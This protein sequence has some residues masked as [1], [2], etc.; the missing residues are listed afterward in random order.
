[1]KAIMLFSLSLLV[2]VFSQLVSAEGSK[3]QIELLVF[4]Q[5]VPTTEVFEQTESLIHWPT[6]LTELAANQY[7]ENKTL[8][9]GAEALLK[10]KGYQVILHLAWMQSTGPGGVILPAHIQSADGRLDG[11]I[12]LRD[13][14]PLELIVDLEHR[15]LQTDSSG[16]PYR[17]HVH[18]KRP[19]KLNEIEYLDHPKL[20]VLAVVKVI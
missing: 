16:K 2:T 8:S 11:Y 10:N 9:N 7:I 1:M 18:E 3:Y 19:I 15:Q 5:G 20:G 17:Y 12:H 13:R 4:S 6:A 14:Q